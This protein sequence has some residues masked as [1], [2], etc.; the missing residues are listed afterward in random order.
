MYYFVRFVIR[1]LLFGQSDQE[2]KAEAVLRLFSFLR[3]GESNPKGRERREK[4]RWTF[5]P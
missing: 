3:K 4:V 5:E 2:K 1:E